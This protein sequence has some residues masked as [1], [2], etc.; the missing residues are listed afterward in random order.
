MIKKMADCTMSML[1][2]WKNMA[3]VGDEQ[4]VKIEMNEFFQKLT[5]DIIAHTAFGSSYAEGKQ[6]FK[7]QRE[8][9]KCCVASFTDIFIP[10][11]Q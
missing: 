5:A 2:E 8:L 7:A 6:A 4:I 10:G 9:Q 3:G 1:D 11:S